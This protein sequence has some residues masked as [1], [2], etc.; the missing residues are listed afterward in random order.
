MTLL[1]QLIDNSTKNNLEL[2]S[3]LRKANTNKIATTQLPI[4]EKYILENTN[5]KVFSEKEIMEFE[6][7]KPFY[8]IQTYSNDGIFIKFV[9]AWY[10]MSNGVLK[11]KKSKTNTNVKMDFSNISVLNKI[12]AGNYWKSYFTSIND[13]YFVVK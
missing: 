13:K 6:N 10:K 11:M 2:N 8:M 7:D 4:L 1:Q 9:G 3:D 12:P 5:S